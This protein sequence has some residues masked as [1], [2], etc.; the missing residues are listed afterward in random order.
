MVIFRPVL[1]GDV[2]YLFLIWNLFLA[3]IPFVLSIALFLLYQQFDGTK[4]RNVLLLFGGMV[5]LVFYPNAPYLLTDFIHLSGKNFDNYGLARIPVVEWYDL[6]MF[7]LFIFTG[8]LLG[9]ISLFLMQKLISNR[10]NRSIGWIFTASVLFISSFGI[11]L[12]RFIRWNTWDILN[13][14]VTLFFGIK[15]SF[16][17]YSAM[18]TICYGLFLLLIYFA[19]YYITTLS[20]NQ[21]TTQ[22]NQRS[23][24]S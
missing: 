4:I 14:P 17:K 9:F 6:I 23:I 2:R 3:W 18:F 15:N 24:R 19:L 5:W 11:Y 1:S 10:F 7:S 20:M 22:S 12:G 16:H 8:F 13:H 21:M